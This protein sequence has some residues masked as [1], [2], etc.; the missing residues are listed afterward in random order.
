[1]QKN[2]GNGWL[3]IMKF[4]P[5]K[6]KIAVTTYSPVLKQ[7]AKDAQ[8]QFELE[9]PMHWD[10]SSIAEPTDAPAKK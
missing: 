7:Y 6:N 10:S 9:W 3:R 1:M 5:A 4:L 2:G 8:N